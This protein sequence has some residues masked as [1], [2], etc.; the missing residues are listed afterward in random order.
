MIE[1]VRGRFACE[2]SWRHVRWELISVPVDAARP[3]KIEKV[4]FL[5]RRGHDRRVRREVGVQKARPCFL[6]AQNYKIRQTFRHCKLPRS[7]AALKDV[8][9][10]I[11]AGSNADVQPGQ[12][13]VLEKSQLN[14]MCTYTE[15]RNRRIFQLPTGATW[16]RRGSRNRRGMSRCRFLV[17]PLANY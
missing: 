6:R 1:V 15:G 5:G 12:D 3:V 8:R 11:S 17:N 2:V 14:P 13:N 16:I 7:P 10:V 9:G 4:E